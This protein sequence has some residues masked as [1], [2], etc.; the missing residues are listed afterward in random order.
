M[1]IPLPASVSDVLL[2][3]QR[4]H[5]GQVDESINRH[6]ASSVTHSVRYDT[7]IARGGLDICTKMDRT[8][9]CI[10]LSS[11]INFLATSHL[12]GLI[13]LQTINLLS[14]GVVGS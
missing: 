10:A 5:D 12:I 9:L 7:L 2:D 13:L 11:S 4:Q 3:A 6:V 14:L 8:V 1:N